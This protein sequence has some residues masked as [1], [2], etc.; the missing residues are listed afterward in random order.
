MNPFQLSGKRAVVTGGASG[1]GHSIAILFAA[2]GAETVVLDLSRD[3]TLH[4]ALEV[5]R[6]SARTRKGFECDVSDESSL[7]AAFSAIDGFGKVDI[8]VNCAGISHVGTLLATVASDMDRL[9]RVNVRGTYLA[10][11]AAVRRM[12]TEKRA[13]F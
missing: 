2:A 1:T 11:Q 12:L 4:V 5:S 10:V 9:C 13:L 6:S 8:L 3:D 7:E